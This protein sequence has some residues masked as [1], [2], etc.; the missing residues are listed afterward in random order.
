MALLNLRTILI[1]DVPLRALAAVA[2]VRFSRYLPRQF[3]RG[4][5][6]S[7]LTVLVLAGDLVQFFRLFYLG[8]VYDPTTAEMSK[9]PGLMP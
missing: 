8:G 1:V 2:I 7:L 3:S 4:F 6:I 9:A 5:W